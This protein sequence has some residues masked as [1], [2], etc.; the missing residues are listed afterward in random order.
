MNL[1]I[2]IGNTIAKIAVFDH[3]EVVEVIRGSNHS[4]DCLKMLCHKYSF[5]RGIIASVITLSKTIRKQLT[6][7]EFPV[8][9]LNHK[10]PIPIHNMYKTPETLG[11]DRLA[12]VVG[13]YSQ[14]PG[15][16]LLVVDAGT[17]ITYEFI[18]K[19][20]QYWGGNISPGIYTRFKTLNA[21]CDK[22]P[23][24]EKEGD[25]PDFG[26]STET[27]IR[28]GVIKG[29]E[30]EITGYITLMRKKYPDLLVFL[31]GGDKFSFD[32]NLKNIIFADR[33]LVL[34]GLNRILDYNV[35]Q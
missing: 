27:A 32:T 29:V 23:L 30:F 5:K 26:Y 11:M 1:I 8:M 2:D 19:K 14:S 31:T 28:A 21:C 17:A 10:T 20:G 22:L 4:L 25:I 3:G 6:E 9:E 18:D 15:K 16:N 34:K 7:L 24:I 13:A 33:F 12:A 35:E